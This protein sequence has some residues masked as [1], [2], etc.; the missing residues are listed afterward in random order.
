MFASFLTDHAAKLVAIIPLTK[1]HFD[2]WLSRQDAISQQW[3]QTTGFNAEPGKVCILPDSSGHLKQVLIGVDSK[4]SLWS[5]A[6]CPKTLP[7]GSYKL[8]DEFDLLNVAQAALG[9]G[10]ACY[11][12][13]RYSTIKN[14]CD[15]QL[16]IP[17]ELLN[18][19][20]P[21]LEACFWVRTLISTPAEDMGP[22][23]LATEAKKMAERCQAN[24]REIVG[25]D[26]LSQGYAGIYTVGKAAIQAPRLIDITWGKATDPKVTLVGKGVCFD[27]G[28][29]N[30][31]PAEYMLTM[32]K[33]MGGAAHVLGLAQLIM[34]AK[35]PIR[36]RVLIPAVENA[37]SKESYRP[38]DIITSRNGKT[39]EVGNTDAEGRIILAD[40]LAEASEEQ[41]ELLIDFATLTGAAR[42]ALGT[43]LPALFCNR[44]SLAA[45]LMKIGNQE[46]DPVW[47]L[48]LHAPY[49]RFIKGKF[50][51][52][53]NNPSTGMGGAINAALFLECFVGENIPWLHIDLMAWNDCNLPGRPEG[54][55]A[56]AMRTL[57]AYL[58][59]HYGAKHVA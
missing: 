30:L 47:Q 58:C 31:K 9:W 10:L 44:D 38:G 32:K 19:L 36:L 53:T 35:L 15:R 28:G 41:P 18:K 22:E 50:A 56:M 6:E 37:V 29:L 49:K 57:F 16:V 59:Q 25:K 27:S 4:N 48:P 43:S 51:D 20:T 40:A 33:D 11:K 39:I 23:N 21:M 26:L 55:E 24:Y 7:V 46:S 3:I 12:F 52:L 54:G 1:S 14:T 13:D 8:E 34:Q 17:T 45:E 42:A 5:L 2:A